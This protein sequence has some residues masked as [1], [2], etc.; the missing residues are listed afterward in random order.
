MYSN[1]RKLRHERKV[2]I[3]DM[4]KLLNINKPTYYRKEVGNIKFSL[5]EAK[6]IA[7][8]FNMPIE[9]VFFTH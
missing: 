2:N 8:Y 3:G 7:K 4:L 6:K 1:L 9:E 5:E